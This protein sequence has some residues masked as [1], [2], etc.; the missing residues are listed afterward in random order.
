MEFY[1]ALVQQYFLWEYSD[2]SIE[3]II[4]KLPKG[5]GVDQKKVLQI[6]GGYFA[7]GKSPQVAA[8]KLASILKSRITT[9]FV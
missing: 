3:E 4:D 5:N 9:L 8:A 6:I 7:A 2:F 1:A